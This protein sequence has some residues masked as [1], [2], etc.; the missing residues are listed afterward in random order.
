M[1]VLVFNAGSSSLKF[2]VFSKG[3]RQPQ[4]LKATYERFGPEGCTF[5]IEAA[6]KRL[7]GRKP[8]ANIAAAVA[9]VPAVLKEFGLSKIDAIGHRVAHGGEEFVHPAVIDQAVLAAIER[10]VPLAPLHNPLSLEG[11][12][13]TR[14]LWPAL[15]QVAVFDTAFHLANPARATTYAVP[16]AWRAVGLRRF[17]VSRYVA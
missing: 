3:D 1:R 13:N 6:N 7:E 14:L 8:L 10:L 12:R 2:G 11:I 9:D 4:L 17:R 16:A 5:R 15:P